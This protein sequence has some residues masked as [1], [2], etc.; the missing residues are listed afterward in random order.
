VVG[1]EAVRE[2]ADVQE[3]HTELLHHTGRRRGEPGA[4]GG[5][6]HTRSAIGVRYPCN[7][8]CGAVRDS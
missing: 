7:F 6:E 4:A 3:V 2:A 8:Q 1:G 5:W